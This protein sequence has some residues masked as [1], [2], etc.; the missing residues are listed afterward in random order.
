MKTRLSVNINKV[1]L[2]RN[3]RGSNLPDL[4]QVAKDCEFFGA[5]GIT[6]H[7]RPDERHVKYTDI[8]LL[9][10]VC[11]TE[12][13]IEG[14]PTPKFMDLVLANPPHQCTLVPDEPSALTS[15][16]GWDTIKHE[17]F[18][19]DIIQALHDANIRVSIF[20]D[21]NPRFIEGAAKVKADRIEFYTGPYAK[22]YH[23]DPAAAVQPY[24]TMASF[25]HNLGLGINAGHD[26]NLDNLAFFQQQVHHLLEV[27]IGHALISDAL[28]YGLENTIQMY[29]QRL[30]TVL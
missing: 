7:P 26:L 13:N 15:D 29:L 3:S 2:L 22:D 10:D 6:V 9:R 24:A 19:T 14:N 1:A 11:T 5:E 20:M 16:Q 17:S 12:F 21:P 23:Q 27:S 4:I 8:P 25:A 18:L 30:N 28:Y